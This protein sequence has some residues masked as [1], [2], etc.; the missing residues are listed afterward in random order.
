MDKELLTIDFRYSD[1]RPDYENISHESKKITIGVFDTLEE[2]IIAGNKTLELLESKFKLHIFP[3]GNLASKERFGI[4]NGCFG[5]PKRLISD[6]A[7][8][9]TPFSFYAKI[10]KLKYD[11]VEQTILNVLD[12]RKRYDKYKKELDEQ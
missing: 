3:K 4:T 6:L 11:D 12:A 8:L 7:Y 9:Q 1:K 10:E 5:N 2:A